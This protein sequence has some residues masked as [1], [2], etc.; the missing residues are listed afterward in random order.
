MWLNC[1]STLTRLGLSGSTNSSSLNHCNMPISMCSCLTEKKK[2]INILL[3]YTSVSLKVF[4]HHSDI[5]TV[6]SRGAM[7]ILSSK[8]EQGD[9]WCHQACAQKTTPCMLKANKHILSPSY[10][11]FSIHKNWVQPRCL[12]TTYTY[13]GL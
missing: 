11:Y 10:K 6:N 2:K 12:H 8:Q 7:I 5:F 4:N 1:Q 13:T 9:F 3:Q